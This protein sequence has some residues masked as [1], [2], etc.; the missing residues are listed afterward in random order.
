LDLFATGTADAPHTLGEFVHAKPWNSKER[1]LGEKETLG[2]Y[3]TGHPIEHYEEELRYFVKSRLADLRAGKETQAAAGL[4]VDIRIKPTKSGGKIAFVTLD[5]RTGR[6]DV[7]VYT[8]VFEQYRDCLRKDAMLVVEGV[9]EVDEYSDRLRIRASKV[10]DMVQ[11]RENYVRGLILQIDSDNLPDSL[12]EQLQSLLKPFCGDFC[13]V[14][15]DY[16]TPT[17]KARLKLGAQ[18][19]VKPTDELIARLRDKFGKDK[20][21]LTYN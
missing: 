14:L 6:M 11:A 4:V 8:Q 19:R 16:E 13:P 7:A 15:I 12:S 18:W 21:K 3:L 20:V 1:L 17:E 2:L 5:D 9:V 10:L